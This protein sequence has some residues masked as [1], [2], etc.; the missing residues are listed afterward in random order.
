MLILWNLT[1]VW[2]ILAVWGYGPR[3]AGCL[4]LAA[5]SLKNDKCHSGFF[6]TRYI[7]H[8]SLFCTDSRSWLVVQGPGCDLPP[9][10]DFF[11]F[12]KKCDICHITHRGGVHPLET[13]TQL[14]LLAP[15]FWPIFEEVSW[16]F[17]FFTFSSEGLRPNFGSNWT[18][19]FGLNWSSF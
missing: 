14:A 5:A 18:P 13:L 19:D 6:V 10:L 11:T 16:L 12:D 7:C 9:P 8:F 1:S 2:M 4:T 15:K 3:V 17:I